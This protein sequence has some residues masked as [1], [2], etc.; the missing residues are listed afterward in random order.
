MNI[1]Y[2]HLMEM[3]G[4]DVLFRIGCQQVPTSVKYCHDIGGP[5]RALRRPNWQTIVGSFREDKTLRPYRTQLM[6][7]RNG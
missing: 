1:Y 7:T 5:V 2:V 6:P 3:D 4:Q